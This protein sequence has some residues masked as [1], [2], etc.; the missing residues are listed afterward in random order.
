MVSD[1]LVTVLPDNQTPGLNIFFKHGNFLVTQA[2]DSYFNKVI[3]K[4][5]ELY[6]IVH[7]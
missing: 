7:E 4:H 1:W 5:K 2:P 3:E 6:F